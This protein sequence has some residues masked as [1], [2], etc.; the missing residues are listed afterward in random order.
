M[1]EMSME[2]A[3]LLPKHNKLMEKDKTGAWVQVPDKKPGDGQVSARDDPAR[4]SARPIDSARQS[5][6]QPLR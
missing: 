1:K 2:L 6:E 4:K 3:A 5:T